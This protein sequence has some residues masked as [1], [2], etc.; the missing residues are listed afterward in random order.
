MYVSLYHVH[1]P[2][3]VEL[4]VVEFDDGVDEEVIV[5]D[6]NAAIVL[7]VLQGAGASLDAIQETH[8]RSELE[9]E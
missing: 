2:K 1:V 7:A 5:A 3:L 6:T 9:Q 4:D 8:A